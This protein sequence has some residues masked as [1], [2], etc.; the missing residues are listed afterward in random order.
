VADSL[1][2]MANSAWNDYTLEQAYADYFAAAPRDAGWTDRDVDDKWASTLYRAAGKW[3]PEPESRAS[4]VT[5]LQWDPAT[6]KLAVGQPS[7]NTSVSAVSPTQVLQEGS[8]DE[9]EAMLAAVRERFARLDW[10]ALSKEK[11]GENWLLRPLVAQ[12]RNVTIYSP[13]KAGKSLLML[14]LAAALASAK[15]AIGQDVERPSRI[16]YVD[17]ENVP[18]A[19]IWP[20]L[21]AMG[22][23][24][25][26]LSNLVYL[27]FP[28]M[29]KLDTEQGGQELD[30]IAEAYGLDFIVIDT[31]SRTISSE[32]N[33]NDTWLA[34]DRHAGQRLKARGIGFIRLDHSGHAG[35]HARGGSAKYGDVDATWRLELDPEDLSHVMLTLEGSR[36]KVED[37]ERVLHLKR[38]ESPLRHEL[39]GGSEVAGTAAERVANLLEEHGILLTESLNGCVEFLKAIGKPATKKTV[40]KAQK[41]RSERLTVYRV[42]PQESLH[43]DT[44]ED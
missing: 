24:P 12:G 18:V 32:E 28:P 29:A 11:G 34:W 19:D 25:D 5:G 42:T 20:R 6:G 33:S 26:E 3:R 23:Q 40:Q 31:V 43:D 22:Y 27:S 1:I 38:L 15:G 2:S 14:E 39:L 16:G 8:D 41:L 37:H 10:E 44:D 17:W 7:A 35:T 30:L 21:L 4:E 36:F 9:R 13:P